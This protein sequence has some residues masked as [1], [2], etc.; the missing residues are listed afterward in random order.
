MARKDLTWEDYLKDRINHLQGCP[1]GTDGGL[2]IQPPRRD[3][4]ARRTLYD[5]GR[6]VVDKGEGRLAWDEDM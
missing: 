6:Q 2:R 1:R 4:C 3:T 5:C